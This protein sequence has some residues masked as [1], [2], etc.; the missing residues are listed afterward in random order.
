M[1][2]EPSCG[3]REV[4]KL[5]V[6]E[7][8]DDAAVVAVAVVAVA[9]PAIVVDEA[10]GSFNVVVTDVAAAF[11]AVAVVED[12]DDECNVAFAIGLDAVAVVAVIAEEVFLPPPAAIV[13]VFLILVESPFD[14]AGTADTVISNARQTQHWI[15][16][17]L[18]VS[19]LRK[20]VV[21]ATVF[22]RARCLPRRGV[23][24]VYTS[25]RR[26]P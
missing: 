17:I 11:G 15:A 24:A 18:S 26:F 8:N 12:D 22:S 4:G 6:D 21:S 9:V 5:T 2:L 13:V 1:G 25:D 16:R 20:V 14:D 23:L 19:I 7:A 3:S 10:V